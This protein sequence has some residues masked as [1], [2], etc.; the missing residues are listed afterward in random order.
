MGTRTKVRVV[1]VANVDPQVTFWVE[2]Q[3]VKASS[4]KWVGTDYVGSDG[5]PCRAVY[6]HGTMMGT[7][8]RSSAFGVTTDGRFGMWDFVPAGVGYGSVSDQGGMN[9]MLKGYGLR[10]VRRGGAHWE[11][12]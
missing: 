8:V 10:M 6:H 1:R 12:L 9:A 7:F 5:L 3:T 2:G 4:G 11:Y